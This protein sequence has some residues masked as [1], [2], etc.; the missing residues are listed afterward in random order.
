VP[1]LCKPE[2]DDERIERPLQTSRLIFNFRQDLISPSG[3][4]QAALHLASRYF[5]ERI[6]RVFKRGNVDYLALGR[7]RTVDI[8]P[9]EALA[10]RLATPLRFVAAIS[11]SLSPSGRLLEY[12]P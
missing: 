12:Q 10:A 6:Q 8:R 4:L 3:V 1:Q 5:L 2:N 11:A 9:H 7:G